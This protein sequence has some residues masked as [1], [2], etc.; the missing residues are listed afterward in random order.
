MLAAQS[1]TAWTTEEHDHLEN[2][3][4]EALP[5]ASPRHGWLSAEHEEAVFAFSPHE[6]TSL[7]ELYQTAGAGANRMPR[8]QPG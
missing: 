8:E 4:I 5:G 3:V 1:C 7:T 6:T 2:K